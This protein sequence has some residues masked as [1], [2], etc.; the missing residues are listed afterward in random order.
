LLDETAVSVL[1]E[2]LHPSI[3]GFVRSALRNQKPTFSNVVQEAELIAR[4]VK[5]PSLA[6]PRYPQVLSSPS[7]PRPEFTRTPRPTRNNAVYAAEPTREVVDTFE[8]SWFD[9]TNKCNRHGDASGEFDDV[10]VA[11]LSRPQRTMCCYTCWRVGHFAADCPLIPE[12]ERAGIAKRRAEVMR[13]RRPR[14]DR[15]GHSYGT[16]AVVDRVDGPADA[17]L[18]AQSTEKDPPSGDST[19]PRGS[20]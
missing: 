5:V 10:L 14:M 13:Q 20:H 8:Q 18:T 19:L 2:G 17:G 16:E 9:D 7:R 4:S 15:G 11:A 3:S 12:A 1:L 6:L